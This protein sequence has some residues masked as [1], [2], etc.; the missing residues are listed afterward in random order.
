MNKLSVALNLIRLL[1]ENREVTSAMVAEDME[2]SL[3]TAQ[4]YLLDMGSLPGVCYDEGR[5]VWYMSER[6]RVSD[7]YLRQDEL[8][9]LSGLFDYAEGILTSDYSVMLKQIKRKVISASN[10]ENI[11]RFLKSDSID[12]DKVA[13]TFS[14]LESHIQ[15]RQE[16]SFDYE[17][18]GKSYTVFP[19]RIMF[20]DGLW[21]LIAGKGGEI[22][23]FSLD[24]IK[25]IRPTGVVYDDVPAGLDEAID[26]AKSMF[27]DPAVKTQ[28]TA[29]MKPAMAEYLSRKQFFPD[30]K[31]EETL[32]DGSVVFTF[33][34]GSH[35]ECAKL[36]LPWLPAIRVKKPADMKL[37]FENI[38]KDGLGM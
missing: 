37:S 6:Y 9:V 10:R 18:S 27:F 7:S 22:R 5:H 23:K 28:V 1:N 33:S 34:A 4:R 30:Q 36:C 15:N 16:I 26:G 19:Y 21:Y 20:G 25:V 29:L 2:I 35:L 11:I 17:R 12:F 38:L 8:A 13:E 3:R 14:A 32:E 31:I 24:Y